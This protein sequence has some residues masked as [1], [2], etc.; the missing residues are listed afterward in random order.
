MRPN[1]DRLD[2]ALANGSDSQAEKH[3]GQNFLLLDTERQQDRLR[4][5]L[6][7]G[8]EQTARACVEHM[9]QHH[10]FR[11]LYDR[12]V[13]AVE[14]GTVPR[15][16]LSV[17]ADL[18]RLDARH[19]EFSETTEMDRTPT[20]RLG[21]AAVS[22]T[23]DPL[24]VG[25]LLVCA[26]LEAKAEGDEQSVQNAAAALRS[27]RS[28]DAIESLIEAYGRNKSMGKLQTSNR[29]CQAVRKNNTE[30]VR[31]LVSVIEPSAHTVAL[32]IDRGMHELACEQIVESHPGHNE[33]D[34]TSADQRIRT[35]NG[36][37]PF[38]HTVLDHALSIDDET[39]IRPLIPDR[40]A[41]HTILDR[42]SHDIE[43]LPEELGERAIEMGW[44]DFLDRCTPVL[45]ADPLRRRSALR[46]LFRAEGDGAK[47]HQQALQ[48]VLIYAKDHDQLNAVVFEDALLGCLQGQCREDF[49][50]LLYRYYSGWALVGGPTLAGVLD[51]E[52]ARVVLKRHC[53]PDEKYDQLYRGVIAYEEGAEKPALAVSKLIDAGLLPKQP[54]TYRDII[55]KALQ[56]GDA[57]TVR[58][59]LQNWTRSSLPCSLD[60]G[61]CMRM[62]HQADYDSYDP[63]QAYS[64][65]HSFIGT[66][67][68]NNGIEPDNQ[69]DIDY[70]FTVFGTDGDVGIEPVLV[71][72]LERNHLPSSDCYRGLSGETKE[73]M[74]EYLTDRQRKAL[75]ALERSE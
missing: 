74:E 37:E 60:F 53:L 15:T 55:H 35:S 71:N 27:I 50:R 14:H 17:L 13:D 9:P 21:T 4:E 66:V 19:A 65:A 2:D 18:E 61:Q 49:L 22:M 57:N 44:Y 23:E 58:P 51:Y 64:D 67:L 59:L 69:D 29:L 11:A 1:V 68:L 34:L 72:L 5:A 46:G 8:Y 75:R 6:R 47:Q 62:V 56:Y 40:P 30:R 32:M 43:K 3:V 63:L 25:D 24:K 7:K 54:S 39:D 48:R 41:L 31:K 16:T 10:S 42:S 28:Q 20:G 73:R 36:F 52:T 12:L 45:F 33:I 26:W 38:R 70:C